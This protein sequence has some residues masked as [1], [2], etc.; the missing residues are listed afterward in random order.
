MEN[1]GDL[2]V[3]LRLGNSLSV[4]INRLTRSDSR[5]CASGVT[6]WLWR[7]E[8]HSVGEITLRATGF[9]Q[10]SRK[11]PIVCA[12]QSLDIAVRGGIS[13]ALP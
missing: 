13:F 11:Q 1:I 10:Y 12:E 9:R 2:R 4:Q 8:C 7:F 5:V 6:D 3:D